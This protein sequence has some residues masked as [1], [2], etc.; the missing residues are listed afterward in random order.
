MLASVAGFSQGFK[1]MQIDHEALSV[2]DLKKSRNFY[3]SILG[4]DSIAEPFKDGKHLWLS[5]GR[6]VQLHII[7]G[8][9]K[10][11]EY[12]QYNHLCLGTDNLESFTKQLAANKIGWVDTN[13]V[14]NKTTTRPD[15]VHQVWLK[16]PDG[17]WIEVNDANK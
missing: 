3:V 11:K 9:P 8:A 6:G 4:L 10:A 2:V 1:K 16:D 5:L 15:G 13:G 14:A 17:Y 12:Y 7:S